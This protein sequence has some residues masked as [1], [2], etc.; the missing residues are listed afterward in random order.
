MSTRTLALALAFGLPLIGCGD[1]GDTGEADEEADAD[2]DTDT[3]ADTD[4][5]PDYLELTSLRASWTAAIKDGQITSNVDANYGNYFSIVMHSDYW[6]GSN[7]DT[8]ACIAYVETSGLEYDLVTYADAGATYGGWNIPA[9]SSYAT[10]AGCKLVDPANQF[11]A[12]PAGI[13]FQKYDWGFGLGPDTGKWAD[14][15]SGYYDSWAEGFVL[16]QVTGVEEIS[17]FNYVVA[18][19]MN[20]K[21]G[22][23]TETLID[24]SGLTNGDPLPDGWYYAGTYAGFT[25]N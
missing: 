17:E 5:D 18:Y 25:F 11:G 2:T 3:D 4:A 24:L 21:G 15:L 20:E 9:G 13:W 1:K 19:A 6:D 7:S 8:E 10:T 14:D 23:D 12:D 22:V 16:H